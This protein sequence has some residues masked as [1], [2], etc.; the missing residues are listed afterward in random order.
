MKVCGK[1]HRPADFLQ[2]RLV[3]EVMTAKVICAVADVSVLQIARLMAENRVSSVMIVQTQASLTIPIGILTERDIVQFQALDLNFDT[4]TAADVMSTPVFC[5]NADESLWA[6][7]QIME[8]RLI[9][10]L[11][12]TGKQ[13]ELLG[14]VTQTSILQVI[15]PL[16][17]YKLTAIL[18]KKV[19]QLEAEKIEL[20]E[21]R[22]V[23]LGQQVDERTIALRKKVEYEQLITKISAQIRS[24]LD[25]E[26]ILNTTVVGIRS[27]LQCDSV[28]IY[29]FRPDFSG[30]VIAE[31]IVAGGI[32]VLH[33]EPYD[34][35]ITAEWLEPY[36]QGQIRVINDIYL[37][38]M[39]ECHQEML[40]GL[41]IRAKLMV[42]II[43]EDQLWG[44]MLTSYRD[45]PYNW[46]LEEIE[47][48][49][50]LSIQ[51]AL[52]IKQA[53]TC[54]QIHIELRQRQQAESALYQLNQELEARVQQ[55]TAELLNISNR[56]ELA[57]KSA[58]IGIWDWNLVNDH[59]IWDNRMYEIYGV[60]ASEFS[61]AVDAWE[62]GLHPEDIVHTREW[63]WQAVRGERDFDPEF[64]I[65]LPDGKV[66]IIQAYAIV[67][68][69][70]Q[71]EGERMI[72]VNIDITKRKQAEQKIKQQVEREHLLLEITQRI[73]Q[74][75]ISLLFL[76]PLLKKP[77]N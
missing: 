74:S 27:L 15:N 11:A 67:Q 25:V 18:E 44:L 24:S 41:D 48:V 42:P 30:R 75:C 29:Q 9:Q 12:V 8:Q 73:R 34:P 70:S 10:R 62:R 63:I 76:I 57:V 5:V 38:S 60:K 21:N 49:R 71:G 37:E 23:E 77:G 47:L 64:R 58:E 6:V 68:R 28:I 2:L 7:Q 20:L 53:H 14:I 72:G 56:L 51:L 52:V 36:R 26:E 59:L 40:I 46:E 43:V 66:R 31:S 13:R 33:S 16:E 3:N 39:T 1:H 4:Y 54:Q 50:Q 35:C 17:L 19:S 55:R 32:S 65:V 45:T 69:N 22:N 61:G